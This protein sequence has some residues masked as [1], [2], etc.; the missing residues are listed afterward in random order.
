MSTLNELIR[1][2]QANPVDATGMVATI[3]ALKSGLADI[4]SNSVLDSQVNLNLESA[5]TGQ[6]TQVVQDALDKTLAVIT[7][8]REA[9]RLF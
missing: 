7:S 5:A 3:A 8:A 1:A 9:S 6:H 2:R 4:G